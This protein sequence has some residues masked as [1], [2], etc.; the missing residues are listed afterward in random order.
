MFINK[1]QI[2]G[3][4]TFNNFEVNLNKNLNIIV[5]TNG[6]GK[7]TFLKILWHALNLTNPVIGE[8][9]EVIHNHNQHFIDVQVNFNNES[10][11]FLKQC[12]NSINNEKYINVEITFSNEMALLLNKAFIYLH[13]K[14]FSGD[15]T[16]TYIANQ[17]KNIDNVIKNFEGF[18]NNI[19]LT[20]IYKNGIFG[21]NMFFKHFDCS[22]DCINFD[23]HTKCKNPC[24]LRSLFDGNH[25]TSPVNIQKHLLDNKFFDNIN[26]NQ[27]GIRNIID[28][29]NIINPKDN[30]LNNYEEI[31]PD[32]Y[33]LDVIIRKLLL[34]VINHTMEIEYKNFSH[35]FNMDK[36]ETKLLET[37]C[38]LNTSY[39]NKYKMF[40]LKNKNPTL[41]DNIKKEFSSLIKK[42]FD[43]IMI[44]NGITVYDYEYVILID[45][46]H[47]I[48]SNG[49]KE[50]IEFL[51]K[52]H[53]NFSLITLVD[54]PCTKLSHQNKIRFRKQ[55]LSNV[56]TKQIIMVT[57][58]KELIDENTCKN[59]LYFR[60]DNNTTQISSPFINNKFNGEHLKILTETPDILFSA[61][62]LL[63]EGYTDYIF[64]NC[65]M[66]VFDITDYCVIATGG[67]G[68]KIHDMLDN[69][70]VTYKMIYDLDKLVGKNKKIINYKCH[71]FIKDRIRDTHILSL[72]DD[73]K[74]TINETDI[75][76]ILFFKNIKF[77][78][79]YVLAKSINIDNW[80][81]EIE[82]F[83]ENTNF[84]KQMCDKF[85]EE[86]TVKGA[87]SFDHS[88]FVKLLTQEYKNIQQD[89]K[90][91]GDFDKLCETVP[92][93]CFISSIDGI[94]KIDYEGIIEKTLNELI[95]LIIDKSNIFIFNTENIDL[96]GLG[97]KMFSNSFKKKQWIKNSENEIYEKIKNNRDS[98]CIQSLKH[99][100]EK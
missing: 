52:Y 87:F 8:L 93:K 56:Q 54:E 91:N 1:V 64:M 98:S 44:E 34:N 88:E 94:T 66:K 79:M 24:K 80:T 59:I 55:I 13:L 96:E 61:K 35:I 69:M 50:L 63:V 9:K 78:V 5:G 51:Y 90:F 32:F 89:N 99:F 57:H 83:N 16:K 49:E 77:V 48:C 67:C 40:I 62:I 72:F 97:K 3:F 11:V 25:K 31:N 2:N 33:P 10:T 27:L 7:T 43:I 12:M 84:N 20:Y 14:K 6:T 45:N 92:L 95:E 74:R 58:D 81:K 37:V 36:T 75:K 26:E 41:F 85:A 23:D 47:Y 15:M 39:A 18:N 17:V 19:V 86:L 28:L 73:I 46:H 38:F 42:N 68:S 53:N 82:N 71:N 76:N 60:L 21:C 100:L 4:A 65:F 70:K 22:F 29:L 30:K